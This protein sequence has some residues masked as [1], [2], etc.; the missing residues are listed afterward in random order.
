MIKTKYVEF[1]KET[2]NVTWTEDT[3]GTYTVF[4]NGDAIKGT[5]TEQDIIDHAELHILNGSDVALWEAHYVK[6]S[7]QNE[8]L[9]KSNEDLNSD[10]VEDIDGDEVV[11]NPELVLA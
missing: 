2:F 3:I 10:N 5:Y 11:I 7:S 8:K 6:I 9:F 1:M 4:L